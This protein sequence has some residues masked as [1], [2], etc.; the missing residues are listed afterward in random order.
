MIS[1]KII[2]NLIEILDK[3]FLNDPKIRLNVKSL[4]EHDL[5]RDNICNCFTNKG[6]RCKNK[7]K[8]MNF[9]VVSI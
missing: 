7:K 8:K 4:L 6:K 3:N 2:D 9:T 1:E 5:L